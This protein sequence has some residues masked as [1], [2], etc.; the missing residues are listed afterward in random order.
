[1]SAQH[2]PGPWIAVVNEPK[3]G[4]DGLLYAV[5][6]GPKDRIREHL[7]HILDG[8]GSINPR[9]DCYLIAAAP[10]LLEALQALDADWSSFWPLGPDIPTSGDRVEAIAPKTAEIWRTARAAIA[11]ATGEKS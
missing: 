1:M 4:N 11:R 5:A 2:T 9:A 3:R 6:T 8:L 10:D 7:C